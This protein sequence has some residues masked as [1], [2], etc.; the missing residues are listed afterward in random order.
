[1]QQKLKGRLIVP[2]WI[3]ST[4]TFEGVLTYRS[5]FAGRSGSGCGERSRW[6]DPAAGWRGRRRGRGRGAA[7][8]PP[9]WSSQ[10]TTRTS[11]LAIRIVSGLPRLNVSLRP[12]F[13]KILNDYWGY[14]WPRSFL[15]LGKRHS[16]KCSL[17]THYSLVSST[18]PIKKDLWLVRR[19]VFA[20]FCSGLLFPYFCVNLCQIFS[21]QHTDSQRT[22][23]VS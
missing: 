23:I 15:R 11:V 19:S 8:P 14:F 1:M 18:L 6:S 3:F 5:T 7:I 20:D 10:T 21:L 2:R 4:T 17:F 22:L 9:T 16:Q 12:I 13:D